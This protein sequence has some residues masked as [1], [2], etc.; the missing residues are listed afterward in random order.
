MSR[1]RDQLR[2]QAMQLFKE[3]MVTYHLNVATADELEEMLV[4]IDQW[5]VETRRV[6][7]RHATKRRRR[8]G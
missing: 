8:H 3:L 6:R 7:D 2:D 5:F 4:L 1:A